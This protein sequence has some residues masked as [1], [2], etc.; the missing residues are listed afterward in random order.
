VLGVL[1]AESTELGAFGPEDV[2]LA[3]SLADAV[4]LALEN[5]HL[6]QA[7]VNEHGRLEAL[8]EASGDGIL[9]ADVDGRLRVVNENATRLL[10]LGEG[11]DAWRERPIHEVLDRLGAHAP[12]AQRALR[13]QL[14]RPGPDAG[15]HD[16]AE[17]GARCL[18][19]SVVPVMAATGHL[20]VLRDVTEER[21]LERMRDDLTHTMVHYLRN[22]LTAVSGALELLE[23]S[24]EADR[25]A[26]IVRIARLSS[27]RMFALV[28]SILDVSRLES[29]SLPL[30]RCSVALGPLVEETLRLQTPL[31]PD[32]G[33]RL[34]SAVSSE[35][36]PAWA[37]RALLARVLQNLVGNALK[38]TPDGHV[39]VEAARDG[40]AMLRVEVADTGS[41]IAEDLQPRLFQKF[42]TGRDRRKGSG[43]GLAFCRLAV[44]A[45]GGRIWAAPEPERGSR[46]SFTL[47]VAR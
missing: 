22:P 4:A 33:L 8:I 24:I 39:R 15:G 36:P 1:N 46:F 5:A 16:V 32:G 43:L 28:N 12:L 3:E 20:V 7:S 42:V 35:L 37:D 44:E 23:A 14:Q 18:R 13:A 25:L 17:V 26:E 6:Y 11:P 40:D 2:L 27:D 41:G 19:I 45:H 47:P 31:V 9:F 38:Y 30:D 10:G 34:E 21:L 29:G